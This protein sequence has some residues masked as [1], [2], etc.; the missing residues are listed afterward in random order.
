MSNTGTNHRFSRVQEPVVRELLGT[1]STPGVQLR[2]A[3]NR[4]A[5]AELRRVLQLPQIAHSHFLGPE[6]WLAGGHVLRWLCGTGLR[7]DET[8][9]D[10]DFFFPSVEALNSTLVSMLNR[11]FSLHGYRAF[12][13]DMRTYIQK[14]VVLNAKSRGQFEKSLSPLTQETIERL[15]LTCVEL[16]SPGG[17]KIQLVTRFRPS[18][19]ETINAF[20]ISICQLLVDDYYLSFGLWTWNDLVQNRFRVEN[21]VWPDGTLRRLFKYSRRGF[22]PYPDTA[23]RVSRSAIAWTVAALQRKVVGVLGPG[24]PRTRY[25]E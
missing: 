20:D 7:S 25:T 4:V 22:L 18:P 17:D 13:R 24:L 3:T 14:T 1:S 19:L 15:R 8:K 21:I 16:L 12:P 9:G 5:I 6:C 11:G 10:F 23:V 2:P